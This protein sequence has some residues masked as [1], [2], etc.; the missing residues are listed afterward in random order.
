[1]SGSFASFIGH[2]EQDRRDLFDAAATRL[3]TSPTYVE[4]DFWVC[5]VL[6][7]IYNRLPAG[8]PRFLFKGGTSL[9]KAFDLIRRFSEDI[10]L[11]V[12]RN[13]LGFEGD[14]DPIAV[15]GLS[16]NKRS[17]LF[18]ELKRACSNYLLGDFMKV[19][20]ASIYEV[21]DGCRVVVDE[22]DKDRQTIL[23]EYPT[24]YP[25]SEIA[26]VAPRVRVE[27]GARSALYPSLTR[28]IVPYVSDELSGSSIEVH[29]VSVVAPQRTYWEKL[30]IL[31]GQHCAYRDL[32]RL[33]SD[34]N[35]LSR[36]YYDAAMITPTETGRTALS[37]LELLNN[38]RQHNLIAFPQAWKRFDQA[39]PGSIRLVP[40]PELSAVIERDYRH[41][42]DMI[43]G[44]APDFDWLREQVERA[45]VAINTA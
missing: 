43:L 13:D 34:R 14:R 10:D 2:T 15:Q 21:S 1:M 12:N 24:L 16:K 36:H 45:E 27:A 41:M 18:G 22:S 5:L 4:K 26:Y 9:S 6:D 33:P 31:H 38:V 42:Q 30:L 17:A 28:K 39:V 7:V 32:E 37:N 35:R 44:D 25:S 11:V 3:D 8:H 40:Q 19:L 23:V 29:N 20:S